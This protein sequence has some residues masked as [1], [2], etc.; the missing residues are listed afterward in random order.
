M[1]RQYHFIPLPMLTAYFC[2]HAN[3]A[4]LRN[5]T[6]QSF[7]K[8]DISKSKTTTYAKKMKRKEDDILPIT[9]NS[10]YTEPATTLSGIAN[11]ILVPTSLPGKNQPYTDIANP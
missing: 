1:A 3:F 5:F 9:R 11:L 8:S 7:T 4:V 6:S 10:A 2:F